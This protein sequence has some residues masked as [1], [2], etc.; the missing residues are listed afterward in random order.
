MREKTHRAY[1][2]WIFIFFY[3]K[4]RIHILLHNFRYVNLFYMREKMSKMHRKAALVNLR[5]IKFPT[6]LYVRA[7]QINI[8]VIYCLIMSLNGKYLFYSHRNKIV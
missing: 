4:N 2:N 3:Y 7:R 1:S 6:L 8:I 5:T